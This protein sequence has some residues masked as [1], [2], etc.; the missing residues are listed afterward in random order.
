L[1]N[2]RVCRADSLG[3]TI[4]GNVPGLEQ[5]TVNVQTATDLSDN[6]VADY[7]RRQLILQARPPWGSWTEYTT[8]HNRLYLGGDPSSPEWKARAR[9]A[10]DRDG[11]KCRECGSPDD[12]ETDH[13]L[14]LSKGGGNEMANL[15]TLCHECHEKKHARPF[16]RFGRRR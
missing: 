1:P 16:N 15:Q 9:A 12:L 5:T 11:R 2:H 8:W 10:K 4:A 3:W 14:P 13:I 7:E 6:D